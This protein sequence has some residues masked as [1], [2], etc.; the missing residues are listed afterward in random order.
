MRNPPLPEIASMP[1]VVT[2]FLPHENV[3]I[4]NAVL[5]IVIRHSKPCKNPIAPT[6]FRLF[7]S[8]PSMVMPPTQKALFAKLKL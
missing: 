4:M 1:N 2:P 3:T 7:K 5:R 8:I 6:H